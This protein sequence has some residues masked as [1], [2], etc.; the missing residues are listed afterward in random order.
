VDKHLHII[1][2]TVPYPVDY[3]GVVDLFYKLPALQAQGVKIHLHCFDYGRGKQPELEKYCASVQYY[4]RNQGH[5]AISNTVPY[6]VSS[7]K[8]EQLLYELLKDDHPILM[9]G[10]HC[11]YPLLDARFAK[12]KCYVRL[13]NVEYQYY[14][15]IA[16][17]NLLAFKKIVLLDGKQAA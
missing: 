13:H 11:T 12:R 5:K 8:N 7:R 2:L 6:I 15:E 14:R 17:S 10:V 1:S 3:G 4:E 9:E 16:G